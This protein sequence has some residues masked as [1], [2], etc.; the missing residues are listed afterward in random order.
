MSKEQ[1]EEAFSLR[2]NMHLK[3]HVSSQIHPEALRYTWETELSKHLLNICSAGKDTMWLGYCA[4]YSKHSQL[5]TRVGHT[6]WTAT[7]KFTEYD[8]KKQ[9]FSDLWKQQENSLVWKIRK[10][11]SENMIFIQHLNELV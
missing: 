11:I 5:P 3:K 2:G 9:M 1:R 4:E 7:Y 10:A 6:I 8:R